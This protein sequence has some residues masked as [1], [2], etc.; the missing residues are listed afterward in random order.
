[1]S[2]TYEFCTPVGS[3]CI[4]Y[5]GTGCTD[6]EITDGDKLTYVLDKLIDCT[7][8]PT[9]STT[10][11]IDNG[12]T[13]LVC[14]GIPSCL[15][16]VTYSPISWTM[17]DSLGFSY[18][19]SN[20]VSSLGSGF[21]LVMSKVQVYSDQSIFSSNNLAAG[22]TATIAQLPAFVD[23]D[24]VMNSG[25]GLVK[26]TASFALTCTSIGSFQVT[27]TPNGGGDITITSQEAFNSFVKNQLANLENDL[28]TK[29]TS[30]QLPANDLFPT[31]YMSQKSAIFVLADTTI[32][33][34]KRLTLLEKVTA[35]GSECVSC[36][37]GEE[38][39]IEAAYNALCDK[40]EQNNELIAALTA[41]IITLEANH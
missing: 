32:K 38:I 3:D 19:L 23:I 8:V 28:E 27:L 35:C 36:P 31:T 20:F 10:T 1:M 11:A 5:K 25:C 41:R 37:G 40:L 14:S 29:L 2:N 22:F 18:D 4:I 15:V 12:F 34:D 21:S 13:P 26:F 30:L 39:G 6:K 24:I 7:N 33:L 17:S 16:G 9:I